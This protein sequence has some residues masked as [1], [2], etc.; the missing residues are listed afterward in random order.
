MY[1]PQKAQASLC[2]VLYWSHSPEDEEA[3]NAPMRCAT[4][5][6][7]KFFAAESKSKVADTKPEQARRR[8]HPL[9]VIRK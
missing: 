1:R 4:V 3:A 6:K 9:T 2:I 8:A 5:S 7:L